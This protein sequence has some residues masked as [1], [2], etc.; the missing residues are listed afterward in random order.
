MYMYILVHVDIYILD[1]PG[2]QRLNLG[3]LKLTLELAD[4]VIACV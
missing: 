2:S 4:D 1:V 3:V